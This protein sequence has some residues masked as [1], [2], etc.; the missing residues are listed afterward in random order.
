M[1]AISPTVPNDLAKGDL[2]S[3]RALLAGRTRGAALTALLDARLEAANHFTLLTCAAWYGQADAMRLLLESGAS[4]GATSGAP[5]EPSCSALYIACQESHVECAR[6]LL[7]ADA[8][9]NQA[10]DTGATPLFIA[11]QN[12]QLECVRMLLA[13]G[14][15]V[16]QAN[17]NGGTPLLVACQKGHSA[18]VLCLLRAGADTAARTPGGRTAL[19]MAKERGHAECHKVLS[20]AAAR[21]EAAA[22]AAAADGRAGADGTS[23]GAA[24]AAVDAPLLGKRVVLSGLSARPRVERPARHGAE[25]QAR[26]VRGGNRGQRRVR[27]RAAR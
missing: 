8:G 10:K 18:V 16:N 20:E 7:G 15:A 27:A 11:C 4:V 24:A 13:A 19:Q 9:V 21:R 6:L 2:T 14:A 26:A 17:A 23:S 5:G 25:F 1:S 22:A 12:G 3:L